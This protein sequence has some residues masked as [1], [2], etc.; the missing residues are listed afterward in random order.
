MTTTSFSTDCD[1]LV[2]G[3]GPTGLTLAAQ[4]LVRG[5][6]TR[7]IDK[8]PGIP[9][10]SRAIA[11]QPRTLETLDMMGI[12]DRF[13]DSGHQVRAVNVYSAT[14]RLVGID[15]AYSGSAY[16]FQLHL[17]QHRTEALLRERVAELGGVV[18]TGS[19]LVVM[20]DHPDVVT[21]TVRDA[22]GHANEISTAFLVGCDGA[23]SRVRNLLDVPFV[24]QPYPWDWLLADARLDWDGRADEVHVF[25][26]PD[27]LPL[28]CIPI[29]EQLWRLSMPVPGDRGGIPPTLEEIQ[30]LVNERG[31][32]HMTVS[33]PETLTCFRCQIRSTSV[34]RRGRVMLAG[35]AVHIHSPAGGQGMNTGMQDATNLAWKLGLVIQ[36]RAPEA[37][38]DSYGQER[39]PV[40]AR[41]L[42]FTE[43]MVRFGTMARSVR[44]TLRDV[45]L[46][47]FRLP[48]VQR[49]LAGRMCQTAV[50]YKGSPLTRPGSVRGLP[51]PGER[52]P[53]LE[54]STPVGPSTLYAALRRGRHLLVVSEPPS[55]VFDLHEY[56][57]AVDVVTVKHGRRTFALVR[58][59]GYVVTAGTSSDT[60]AIRGYLHGVAED[61]TP[62]W[63]E[64]ARLR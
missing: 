43:N 32:G 38:L 10:L 7:I 41:V 28:A 21:A 23:H 26:R 55:D 33:E 2:V 46:P 64:Q 62:L 60:I 20:A 4:L 48:V 15:M 13:L 51:K 53:N 14:R 6:R 19:E 54:V 39:G 31:P 25:A 57:D 45:S 27:G 34:Y 49:R 47:A 11:V 40:A 36:R 42:G 8:D 22:T 30:T 16:Q 59:D 44:R 9:R 52:M 18:E 56:R 37:L 24:G 3:A 58:P 29:T 63:M 35:D 5:I 61:V 50:D 1:V 17:P 12:A